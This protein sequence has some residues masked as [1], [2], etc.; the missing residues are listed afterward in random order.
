MDPFYSEASKTPPEDSAVTPASSNVQIRSGN[1]NTGTIPY[2]EVSFRTQNQ[3]GNTP[4]AKKITKISK[5]SDIFLA[6]STAF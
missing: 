3:S 5:P 4:T 2:N 1:S 6:I